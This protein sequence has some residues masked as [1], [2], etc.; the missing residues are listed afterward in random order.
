MAIFTRMIERVMT[1]D[2]CVYDVIITEGS[3]NITF[4]CT[5]KKDAESLISK[6]SQAADEHTLEEVCEGD[7]ATVHHC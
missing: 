4:E 6:F 3:Q 7:M 2:S 1:D 5:S